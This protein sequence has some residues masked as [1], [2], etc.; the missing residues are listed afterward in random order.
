MP[1]L[2]P[3]LAPIPTMPTRVLGRRAPECGPKPRS[4]Q[5]ELVWFC[6]RQAGRRVLFA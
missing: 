5:A 3:P 6:T 4:L 2:S 1:A